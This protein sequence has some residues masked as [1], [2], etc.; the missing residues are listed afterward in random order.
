MCPPWPPC[1]AVPE[2]ATILSLHFLSPQGGRIVYSLALDLELLSLGG[3]L[4]TLHLVY[5]V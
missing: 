1:S 5:T 4:E 3:I 2:P